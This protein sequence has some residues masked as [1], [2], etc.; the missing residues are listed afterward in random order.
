MRPNPKW[1]LFWLNCL[2]IGLYSLYIALI[3][4]LFLMLFPSLIIYQCRSQKGLEGVGGCD[5]PDIDFHLANR[6]SVGK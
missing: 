1:N 4:T 5:T 6:A 3:Q 2:Y